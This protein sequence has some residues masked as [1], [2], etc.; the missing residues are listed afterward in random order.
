MPLQSASICYM[1]IM[2]Q[3]FG[4]TSMLLDISRIIKIYVLVDMYIMYMYRCRYR[5]I[6]CHYLYTQHTP[7]VATDQDKFLHHTPLRQA[8]VQTNVKSKKNVV[9]QFYHRETFPFERKLD[10]F[11]RS[12]PQSSC[13]S[14]WIPSLRSQLIGN[15]DEVKRNLESTQWEWMLND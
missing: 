5:Y 15:W 9:W 8:L 12:C 3:R 14:V 1:N 2:Y 7:F 13:S 11:S 10:W 6:V 4:D